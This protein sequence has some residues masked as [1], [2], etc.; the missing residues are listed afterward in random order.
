V[1][2]NKAFG[3]TPEYTLEMS[4]QVLNAMLIEYNHMNQRTDED[5]EYE[6]VEIPTIDGVKKIKK[7]KDPSKL[8]D[9]VNKR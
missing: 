3:F 2:A 1:I 5:D 8:D 9:H 7:Y 4:Y 6:W